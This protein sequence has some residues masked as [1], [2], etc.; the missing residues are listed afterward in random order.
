M[1]TQ[2]RGAWPPPLGRDGWALKGKL[3]GRA[4]SPTTL[5]FAPGSTTPA[6]EANPV[7]AGRQR[8]P[9][10]ES[11]IRAA[12]LG[13]VLAGEAQEA[14]ELGQGLQARD[15]C[16]IVLAGAVGEGVCALAGLATAA[17]P[18]RR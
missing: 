1:T 5:L 16:G 12:Q 18:A 10:L 2:S 9:G 15:R 7:P 13:P 14:G 4:P 3:R 8:H 11:F 6:Q 17:S